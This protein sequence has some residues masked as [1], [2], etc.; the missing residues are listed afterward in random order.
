MNKYKWIR[1][2]GKNRNE[3]RKIMEEHLGR[4]LKTNEIVHHIDE[5]KGNNKIENLKLMSREKHAS[6]HAK[7]EPKIVLNCSICGQEYFWPVR[8]Y[9]K[10]I[11]K[12]QKRF[13]CS[14]KCVGQFTKQFLPHPKS[15]YCRKMV[16]KGLE[17][18]LSGYQIQKKYGVNRKTAY[19][20]KK[21]LE[22]GSVAV[23]P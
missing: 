14:K 11:K 1:E 9:K 20:I 18:N 10:A 12:E 23:K 21:E 7:D 19:K 6:Y 5:N 8:F 22:S 16:L 13:M 17:K 4:K 15:E 2:N 3:H